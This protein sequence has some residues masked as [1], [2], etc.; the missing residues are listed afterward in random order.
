MRALLFVAG[1]PILAGVLLVGGAALALGLVQ[2]L[3]GVA[4]GAMLAV[5][6]IGLAVWLAA[7]ARREERAP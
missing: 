7:L 4:L 1:V 2:P 3:L 6:V 5:L